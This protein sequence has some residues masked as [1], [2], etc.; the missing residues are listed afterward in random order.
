MPATNPTK[1]LSTHLSPRRSAYL[2]TFLP[3]YLPTNLHTHGYH[4][5]PTSTSIV[6]TLDLQAARMMVTSTKPARSAP[7]RLVH[8][9][10][11]GALCRCSCSCWCSCRR[12]LS[13]SPMAIS[14]RGQR[15]QIRSR[16]GFYIRLGVVI[17]VLGRY[18][19]SENM[20]P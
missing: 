13:G 3:T 11:L 8:R 17:V 20:D 14:P 18:L 15:T 7:L 16:Q 5:L 6:T 9:H 1:H 4:C 12:C 10:G 19:V 2:P